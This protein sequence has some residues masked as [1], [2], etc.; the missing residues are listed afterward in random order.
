ML[1]TFFSILVIF[2]N[3]AAHISARESTF[4]ESPLIV[5]KIDDLKFDKNFDTTI[6]LPDIIFNCSDFWSDLIDNVA[7]SVSFYYR[8]LCLGDLRWYS[9]E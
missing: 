7:V 2:C 3:D 1:S 6:V 8:A 4:T 9:D 5:A